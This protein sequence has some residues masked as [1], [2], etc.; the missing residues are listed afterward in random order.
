VINYQRGLPWKRPKEYQASSPL[1]Q[2]KDSFKTPT[3]FH[4]G[5]SDERVPATHS[6]A[7]H[8]ALHHYLNVPT[9]LV[10]YPKDP[11][12]LSKYK[13]R[14]GKMKWDQQWFDKYVR[15]IEPQKQE[16]K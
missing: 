9:E 14:L 6:R 16:P 13:H 3:L 7:F 4:V 2:I 5:E 1:F 12:S 10:I 11:H 8:R 15:G